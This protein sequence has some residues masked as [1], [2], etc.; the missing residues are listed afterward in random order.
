MARLHQRL[1]TQRLDDLGRGG[2]RVHRSGRAFARRR[3]HHAQQVALKRLPGRLMEPSA[4]VR[5]PADAQPQLGLGVQRLGQSPDHDLNRIKER[6]PPRLVAGQTPTRFFFALAARDEPERQ[7]LLE[8]FAPRADEGVEGHAV[9]GL[10][11]PSHGHDLAECEGGLVADDLDLDGHSRGAPRVEAREREA[12]TWLKRARGQKRAERLTQDRLRCE[13][14]R[15]LD[16]LSAG[17]EG[18]LQRRAVH[19]PVA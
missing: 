6:R 16:G 7:G 9:N 15:A 3:A 4:R 12:L 5:R 2:P 11:Y 19:A 14:E 13:R 8:H 10:A 17:V 18:D 1:R